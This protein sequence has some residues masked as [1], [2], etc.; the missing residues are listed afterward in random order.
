M[1]KKLICIALTLILA[2]SMLVSGTSASAYFE[3]GGTR[4]DLYEENGWN[5]FYYTCV[6]GPAFYTIR[7]GNCIFTS[8]AHQ[9][10]YTLGVYVQKQDY[11]FTMQSYFDGYILHY[12]EAYEKGI[13]SDL[14]ALVDATIT[15]PIISTFVSIS[16]DANNDMKLTI[17]DVLEIQ[18]AILGSILIFFSMLST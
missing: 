2:L 12:D 18:K 16:G 13:V 17:A 1:L 8:G 5:V 7:I 4:I 15:N 9:V 10:P 6:E 14:D 11:P 3:D